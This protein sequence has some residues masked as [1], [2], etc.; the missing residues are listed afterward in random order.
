MAKLSVLLQIA[1]IIVSLLLVGVILLQRSK[2]AGAGIT[3]GGMGESLFGAEVGNVLTRATIV[4]GTLFVVITIALTIVISHQGKAGTGSVMDS[5]PIAP[6][7][8]PA[9]QE[10]LPPAESEPV[11]PAADAAAAEE[12][13]ATASSAPVETKT[14]PAEAKA[15]EAAAPAEAAPEAEEPAK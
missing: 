7:A 14:A 10:P 5:V 4:L 2:G 13:V 9:Q 6:V 15:P 11:S 1:L 3:F 12:V 8:A